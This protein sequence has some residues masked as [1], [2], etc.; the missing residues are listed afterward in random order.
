M[1]MQELIQESLSP[2]CYISI[3]AYLNLGVLESYERKTLV[4]EIIGDVTECLGDNLDLGHNV[5]PTP[6]PVQRER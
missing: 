5:N 1:P 4:D 2:D 3:L 6:R